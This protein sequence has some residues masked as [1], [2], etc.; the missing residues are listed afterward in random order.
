MPVPESCIPWP[1]K[2]C[3]N[4]VLHTHLTP[5]GCSSPFSQGRE[6]SWRLCTFAI[7]LFVLFA[8]ECN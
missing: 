1:L 8:H 2:P 5:N 7:A 3:E 6:G 4:Y